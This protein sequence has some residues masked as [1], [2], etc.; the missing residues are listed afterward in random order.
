[1]LATQLFLRCFLI[2]GYVIA[3]TMIL[4]ASEGNP[5]PGIS[6]NCRS[7][8]QR[9]RDSCFKVYN[10][11]N[12][13]TKILGTVEVKS[14]PAMTIKKILQ[15]EERPFIKF[16]KKNIEKNT[17]NMTLEK[18]DSIPRKPVQKIFD[19]DDNTIVYNGSTYRICDLHSW[20]IRN[21]GTKERLGMGDDIKALYEYVLGNPRI[22]KICGKNSSEYPIG[23][24]NS[25]D[26]LLI[27]SRIPADHPEP[28]IL[29]KNNLVPV[30]IK[31]S[32]DFVP[33]SEGQNGGSGTPFRDSSRSVSVVTLKTTSV[34]T[35]TTTTTTKI[36]D[37][38]RIEPIKKT[39]TQTIL[40]TRTITRQWSSLHRESG[41]DV[42][43]VLKTVFVENS[44]N[45]R[46]KMEL[47]ENQELDTVLSTNPRKS[48][49]KTAFGE[50]GNSSAYIEILEKIKSLLSIQGSSP[51]NT[52]SSTSVTASKPRTSVDPQTITTTV[53]RTRTTTASRLPSVDSYVKEAGGSFYD[54][55]TKEL[56]RSIF[57]MLK[58]GNST[59][60]T[61]RLSSSTSR[62]TITK[63][64]TTTITKT[65]TKVKDYT[66]VNS[67]V[68][69]VETKGPYILSISSFKKE[70]VPSIYIYEDY[71]KKMDNLYQ[72]IVANEEQ[73]KNLMNTILSIR[74]KERDEDDSFELLKKLYEVYKDDSS[75]E[76]SIASRLMSEKR[77]KLGP[78]PYTTGLDKRWK[79]NAYEIENAS[80]N[81]GTPNRKDT[82][83]EISSLSYNQDGMAGGSGEES[84][85]D[86]EIDP[87]LS[88]ISDFGPLN[89][90]NHKEHSLPSVATLFKEFSSKEKTNSRNKFMKEKTSIE[91]EDGIVTKP[92]NPKSYKYEILTL[93]RNGRKDI[94]YKTVTD[95]VR[96]TVIREFD[97]SM[98]LS[99]VNSV[100][101]DH[102]K[103]LEEK[104]NEFSSKVA[105]IGNELLSLK[106]AETRKSFAKEDG[107]SLGRISSVVSKSAIYSGNN[108]STKTVEPS[109]VFSST[110]NIESSTTQKPLL[111]S[112]L[113]EETTT[114]YS[115]STSSA[116]PQ[117]MSVGEKSKSREIDRIVEKIKEKKIPNESMLVSDDEVIGDIVQKLGPLV[118]DIEIVSL[119]TAAR[120]REGTPLQSVV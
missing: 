103:R 75:Y 35:T 28:I 60:F 49:E 65:S 108:V 11:E 89:E 120:S 118:S 58:G 19:G 17:N 119:S 82:I 109:E 29:E 90:K 81:L 1:M 106:A 14:P 78:M 47:M 55:H 40:I 66:I 33:D 59:A 45:R 92:T 95:T 101:K 76:K 18:D 83:E 12:K 31:E 15:R 44:K 34:T 13:G 99:A 23:Y 91:K 3:Q 53:E 36:R 94:E 27:S 22:E 88:P 102:V 51:I 62:N 113:E 87:I 110:T 30:F 86:N 114:F 107:S 7:D 4:Q 115:S 48:S 77:L 32:F 39:K 43:T 72:R 26:P 2:A 57:D 111:E 61:K 25:T 74:K 21:Y 6:C 37:Q 73:Y 96:T 9:C 64:T 24:Q 93:S 71:A 70:E 67:A 10:P 105:H 42:K 46:S 54:D 85:N 38:E 16:V 56:I 112:D 104:L 41:D 20:A 8:D 84:G 98:H 117:T 63:E 80:G 69:P 52:S 68:P 79:D 50:V 100:V 97:S 5:V 116:Y